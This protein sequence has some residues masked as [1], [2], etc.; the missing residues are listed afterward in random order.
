MDSKQQKTIL[1]LEKLES[2]S[3]EFYDVATGYFRVRS[4]SIRTCGMFSLFLSPIGLVGVFAPSDSPIFWHITGMLLFVL[5]AWFGW[6]IYKLGNTDLVLIKTSRVAG[7]EYQEKALRLICRLKYSAD[8]IGVY[9]LR[10]LGEPALATLPP[11][12]IM[13]R[14]REHTLLKKLFP[15]RYTDHAYEQR[16]KHQMGILKEKVDRELKSLKS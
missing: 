11:A 5:C 10:R 16:S 13:S 1:K 4:R 9:I 8:P 15:K 6:N 7:S 14:K 12:V 3:I 2:H